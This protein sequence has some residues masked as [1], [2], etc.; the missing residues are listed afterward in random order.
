MIAAVQAGASAG[1]AAGVSGIQVLLDGAA[2]G[3]LVAPYVSQTIA[4]DII[5]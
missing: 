3:R 4:R 1:S 2:V 5:I